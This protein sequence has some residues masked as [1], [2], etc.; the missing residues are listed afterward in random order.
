MNEELRCGEIETYLDE[1]GLIHCKTCHGIISEEAIFHNQIHWHHYIPKTER[2]NFKPKVIMLTT[3]SNPSGY[4][5]QIWKEYNAENQLFYPIGNF[6]CDVFKDGTWWEMIMTE[7]EIK[8]A[9]VRGFTVIHNPKI[10]HMK[11]WDNIRKCFTIRYP[12]SEK[13]EEEMNCKFE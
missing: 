7:N 6:Q 10:R 5:W 11:I 13:F 8:E 2:D 3:P 4:F 12:Y 1:E 9:R